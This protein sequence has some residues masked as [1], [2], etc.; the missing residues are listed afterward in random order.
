M[1]RK[2]ELSA[3]R[4]NDAVDDF[5][6]FASRR[7]WRY[8][9]WPLPT[10]ELV[11]ARFRHGRLLAGVSQRRIAEV[12]GISQSVV[13][14]FERGLVSHTSAERIVRLAM[15]LGP[16]F[17]FGCCPHTHACDWPSDPRNVSPIVYMRR[18]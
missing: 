15:A 10:F 18:G 7:G 12:A 1:G 6:Q 13:S 16:A 2:R 8:D 14:R 17:P 3:S 4:F 9:Q 5:G 11:G